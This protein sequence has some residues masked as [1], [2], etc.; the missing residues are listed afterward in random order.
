MASALE[1]RILV[2]LL[3][4]NIALT[5]C[6]AWMGGPPILAEDP[7]LAKFF[8]GD[9][10]TKYDQVSI[11][12]RF[13]Q[14]IQVTAMPVGVAIL[15]YTRSTKL[16]LLLLWTMLLF[17]GALTRGFV[18]NG[19][20]L[21]IAVWATKTRQRWAFFVLGTTLLIGFGSSIFAILG[22]LGE[23]DAS[24][25]QDIAVG[26]PDIFDQLSLF[27]NFR[28]T[29]HLTYGLS[30]VG[31][32]I[33]GNFYYN[34]SVLSL[35]IANDVTDITDL[36]SGGFRLSPP[37][38]GFVAFYWV[39]ALV[40]PTLSGYLLSKAVLNLRHAWSRDLLGN[41]IATQWFLVVSN[42]V[43]GFYVM[44]YSAAL[45]ALIFMWILRPA[46]VQWRTPLGPLW[47]NK[48]TLGR[49]LRIRNATSSASVIAPS[50]E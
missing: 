16:G 27:S 5:L 42:V 4:A 22:L 44:T 19:L 29:E 17:A 2:T 15:T 34:P 21:V 28:F 8:R 33:P 13:A 25:W 41:V 39:G 45:S 36:P 1:P 23:R 11:M 48:F 10:K 47:W 31:G 7:F 49:P 50:H 37:L 14:A 30:F 3:V 43:V 26:A 20:L 12:Y 35:L 32:L 40:V 38:Y 24:I 9:Y 6:F 46:P 18:L